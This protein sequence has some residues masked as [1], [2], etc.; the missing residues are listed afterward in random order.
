MPP[1]RRTAIALRPGS[2][3]RGRRSVLV[4]HVASPGDEDLVAGLDTRPRGGGIRADGADACA[5]SRGRRAEDDPG[6]GE[7]NQEAA[8]ATY[9]ACSFLW[10]S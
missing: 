3:E 8:H 9:F 5:D 6:G 10:G 4:A 1:S 2:L 7:G